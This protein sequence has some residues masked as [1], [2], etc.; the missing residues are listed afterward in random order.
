MPCH[1]GTPLARERGRACACLPCVQRPS[2]RN[3]AGERRP[4]LFRSRPRAPCPRPPLCIPEWQEER[5][6]PAPGVSRL[7]SPALISD[8]EMPCEPACVRAPHRARPRAATSS[9]SHACSAMHVALHWARALLPAGARRRRRNPRRAR[10]RTTA[11]PGAVLPSGSHRSAHSASPGEQGGNGALCLPHTRT[12]WQLAPQL[13]PS[14]GARRGEPR[15]GRASFFLFRVSAEANSFLSLY[16]LS[17]SL[18]LSSL[19]SGLRCILVL[20]YV[21]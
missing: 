9:A 20:R 14:S 16:C 19:A 4:P 6:R 3:G 12:H 5:Q 7:P 2:G 1:G 8:A 15:R 10:I 18:S 21:D 13:L 11:H 17:V